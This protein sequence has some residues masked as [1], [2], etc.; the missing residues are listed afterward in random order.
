MLTGNCLLHGQTSDFRWTKYKAHHSRYLNSDLMKWGM[1]CPQEGGQSAPIPN[2]GVG[3][4]MVLE[5]NTSFLK[6]F[7]HMTQI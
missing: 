5:T 1:T 3:G 7:K 4:A 6:G 2:Q